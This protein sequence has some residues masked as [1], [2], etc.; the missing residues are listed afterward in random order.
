[1]EG[2]L[3]WVSEA[4]RRNDVDSVKEV[5]FLLANL[6]YNGLG[7]SFFGSNAKGSEDASFE[8]PDKWD[9]VSHDEV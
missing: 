2:Q 7:L 9:G 4:E 1:M 3:H 5:S 8:S 6:M